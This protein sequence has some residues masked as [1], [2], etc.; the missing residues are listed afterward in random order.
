MIK[1]LRLNFQNPQNEKKSPEVSELSD[2]PQQLNQTFFLVIGEAHQ[3]FRTHQFFF[4]SNT[5]EEEKKSYN[6]FI[7]ETQC[8]QLVRVGAI[9][10]FTNFSPTAIRGLPF[11]SGSPPNLKKEAAE[12]ISKTAEMDY[13][14]IKVHDRT[15]LLKMAA[16][17]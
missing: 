5:A 14:E 17:F 15:K 7:N 13:S 3:L 9:H 11:S 1:H 2:F 10:H 8:S 6:L 12:S 4:V 16:E